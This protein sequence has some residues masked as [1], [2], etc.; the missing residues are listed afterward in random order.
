MINTLSEKVRSSSA[1]ITTG[2]RPVLLVN[3]RDEEGNPYELLFSQLTYCDEREE[4]HCDR[5]WLATEI[6]QLERW[7]KT[8]LTV[9]DHSL[10]TPISENEWDRTELP[11]TTGTQ[12]I[13]LKVFDPNSNNARIGF[14]YKLMYGGTVSENMENIRRSQCW[15]EIK[16]L[17]FVVRDVTIDLPNSF[18]E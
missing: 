11:E 17:G 18:W 15:E 12:A 3:L 1:E 4:Y 9:A 7:Y 6:E 10:V 14:Q 16:L 5:K 13:V 2:G 8:D